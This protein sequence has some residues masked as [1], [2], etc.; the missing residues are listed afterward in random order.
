MPGP[1]HERDVVRFDRWAPHYDQGLG[2]RVFFR[3]LYREVLRLATKIAPA[4]SKVLDVGCGTGLL[5]RS[6]A[7][8]YPRAE[9]AGIDP[10]GEMIRVASAGNSPAHAV[11]FVQGQAESL[12][13]PDDRFGLI[14]STM[15]FHHWADQGQGLQEIARVLAPAGAFI[16]ADHFV[17]RL[18]R[19]FY[20]GRRRQHRFHTPGEIDAMLRQAGL[21]PT[22]WHDVYHVGP[23]R[24][25]GAVSATKD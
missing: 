1:N 10:S 3:P 19:P 12:P 5:L 11:E 21:S 4:P 22:G 15:S 9:L 8:R 17:T 24:I 2:Q 18:Q 14:L 13:Y 25:I 16:L 23:L 20:L 7:P 6:A